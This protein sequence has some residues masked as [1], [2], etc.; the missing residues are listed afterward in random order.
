MLKGPFS[1]ANA[2][3]IDDN[4]RHPEFVSPVHPAIRTQFSDFF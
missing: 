2:A 3:E 1:H 4:V